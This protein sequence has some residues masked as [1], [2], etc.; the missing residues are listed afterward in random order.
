MDKNTAE[1][2]EYKKLI[3]KNLAEERIHERDEA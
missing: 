1:N 3:K 2:N